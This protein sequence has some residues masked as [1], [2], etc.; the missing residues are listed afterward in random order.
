[1]SKKCGKKMT[2]AERFMRKLNSIRQSKND[3]HNHDVRRKNDLPIGHPDNRHKLDMT[4]SPIEKWLDTF[5]E[6]GEY[7]VLSQGGV[8]IFQPQGD[9]DDWFP[10]VESFLAVC[11]T[12]E[13]IARNVGVPDQTEPMRLLARKIHYD[14]PLAASEITA[15]K[16]TIAW[17]RQITEA[18]TPLQFSDY[19]VAI[20]IR[21]EMADQRKAA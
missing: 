4:F 16:A 8:A 6:T 20:Q 21:A 11:D 18:L 10:I 2:P 15:A 12:Y 13:L 7:D 17:M 19:T 9:K 1:M 14:M 3:R 5:K